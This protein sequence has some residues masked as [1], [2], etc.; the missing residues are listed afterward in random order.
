MGHIKVNRNIKCLIEVQ[1]IDN[2]QVVIVGSTSIAVEGKIKDILIKEGIRIID[3]VIPDISKIYKMSDLYV[4]PVVNNTE[5]I[6]MPL[7][8]LEAMSCNLPVISTRFGGLVDYFE[9]DTGFRYFNTTEELIELVKRI[10]G[11]D[12]VKVYN[13]KKIE[14]FTWHRFTNEIITSCNKLV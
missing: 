5:A 6:D 2:I 13:D 9:E 10:K 1:K 12:S 7:S 4:F 8:V 11:M 14:P 3:K